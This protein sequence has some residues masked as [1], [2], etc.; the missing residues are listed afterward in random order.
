MAYDFSD[1]S[2][3]IVEDNLPMV[4]LI[5]SLLTAFGIKKISSARDGEEGF[6]LYRKETFDLVITDWMMKP[7]DGISLTR[8][9]RN[10]PLSPN[11]YVPVILMTGFSEKRRVMQARDVGVTE[12]LVKP[13]N[14]RDLYRR[15]AQIIE[16]PRQFVRSEDFFGPDRRRK[17]DKGYGGRERRTEPV[18]INVRNKMGEA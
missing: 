15:I 13:F 11:Q 5:K 3:L 12:F 16:K 1:V 4:E 17:N 7:V 9:L 18:M 2:V 8:R 10:D 6:T 14:A